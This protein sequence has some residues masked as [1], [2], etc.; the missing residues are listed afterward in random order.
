MARQPRWVAAGIY[1]P[2]YEPRH[3][4]GRRPG[5]SRDRAGDAAWAWAAVEAASV[6]RYPGATGHQLVAVNMPRGG[7]RYLLVCPRCARRAARL[8]ERYHPSLRRFETACRRCWGLRYRSQYEGRRPEAHPD[9]LA[10]VTGRQITRTPRDASLHPCASPRLRAQEY[11]HRRRMARY[12][13][14][15]ALLDRRQQRHLARREIAE[16]LALMILLAR[17]EAERRHS[18]R[19][20]LNQVLWHHH[21]PTMRTLIAMRETPEWAR[22][23]L[24]A[25]LECAEHGEK[26]MRNA[27]EGVKTALATDETRHSATLIGQARLDNLRAHYAAL[28]QARRARRAA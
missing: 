25:A 2:A 4:Y 21:E 10:S 12:E 23:V 3:A 15:Q 11:T 14:M 18:W 9:Y 24:A 27:R 22:Q 20:I 6:A 8:Y 7:V 5:T 19:H 13:A 26:P 16:A 17:S 1:Q 28:G